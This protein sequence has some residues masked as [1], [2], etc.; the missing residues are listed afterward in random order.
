MR[1]G[2]Y[3]NNWRMAELHAQ[4][5]ARSRSRARGLGRAVR[6][7]EGRED[8][9]AQLRRSPV[10]APGPRRRSN[11][12]RADSNAS[13]SRHPSGHRRAHGV[14]GRS[15]CSRTATASSGAFAYERER[16]R[17]KLFQ[18]EGCRPRDR[19]RRPRLQDHEQQ[20]GIHRRRPHA[21]LRRGRRPAR[22]GV[23]A[24]PS[25]RHDLAARASAAFSSPKRCAAKAASSRTARAAASCSTTSRTTTRP[26][27]PTTRKKAGDT[28]R[29]TRPRGGRPNC[30]RA[31]TW[32]AA[33]TAR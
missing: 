2:Q 33:S 5:G 4:G 10:S 21:R 17:F 28:R 7:H 6:S 1:G 27:P 15:G 13:G 31:I 9:A 26:R 30:S 32:R 22:H 8:P 14:H 11:R 16:G 24:V 25:D 23:R 29:A 3:V 19:R 12:P 18:G 20:L